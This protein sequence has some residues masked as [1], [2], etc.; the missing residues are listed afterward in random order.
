LEHDL[1]VKAEKCLFFQHA[2]SFLGY[3]ISTS[4]V[5]MVT[6]FPMDKTPILPA[7]CLVEPVVYKAHSPPVSRLYV[8]SA[9][10]DQFIY[11]AHTSPSSSHPEIGRTVRCLS[12]K[13]WWPT[14]AKDGGYMFPPALCAPSVRLLDT[15][16]NVSY[17]PYLFHNGLGHNCRWIF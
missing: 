1:Y 7:A 4:G 10:R 16:P 5:E 17:I 9:V 6:A 11:W 2:I 15:F 8:P 14:L 13:Y 12:G 3:C